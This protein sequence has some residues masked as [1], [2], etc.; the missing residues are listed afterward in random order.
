MLIPHSE[1]NKKPTNSVQKKKKKSR[2]MDNVKFYAK[3]LLAVGTIFALYSSANAATRNLP[4]PTQ[5]RDCYQNI[6]NYTLQNF[7]GGLVS[8]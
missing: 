7:V 6:A 1:Q 5:L 2:T 3:A 8:F 4:L